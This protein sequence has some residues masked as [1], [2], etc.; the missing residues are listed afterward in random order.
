MSVCEDPRSVKVGVHGLYL[1]RGGRAGVL[2]PQV[3]VEQGWNL[4]EYLGYICVK[5]GLP[6]KSYEAPD[7]TLYT[8][9]AVVF[10]E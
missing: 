6:D 3:P 1:I 8:F 2:L 7:A 9:T 5:A 4:D 10:G